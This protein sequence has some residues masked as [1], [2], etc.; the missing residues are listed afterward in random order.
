MVSEQVLE[1]DYCTVNEGKSWRLRTA[2]PIVVGAKKGPTLHL[3]SVVR[4]QGW[5]QAWG[6]SLAIAAG[7]AKAAAARRTPNSTP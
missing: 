6:A 5:P 4:F 3:N 2:K 1:D 7:L